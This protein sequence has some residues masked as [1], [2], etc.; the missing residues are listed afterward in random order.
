MG[1][2]YYSRSPALP[3]TVS[4]LRRDVCH[5]TEYESEQ[6]TKLERSS[7]NRLKRGIRMSEATKEQPTLSLLVRRKSLMPDGSIG[8]VAIGE[9]AGDRSKDLNL[10]FAQARTLALQINEAIGEDSR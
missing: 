9:F 10:T 6:F 7:S 2:V 3:Y 1:N 8:E 4:D 5:T